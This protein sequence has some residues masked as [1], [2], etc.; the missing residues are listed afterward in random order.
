MGPHKEAVHVRVH[1]RRRT[2]SAFDAF[3]RTL[4]SY[5]PNGIVTGLAAALDTDD[6]EKIAAALDE[7]ILH[8]RRAASN[9]SLKK[10]DRRNAG[11]ASPKMRVLRRT[12]TPKRGRIRVCSAACRRKCV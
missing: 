1:Y 5:T 10:W 11:N 3:V 4:S 8:L 2:E 12:I 7:L 6:L 9:D